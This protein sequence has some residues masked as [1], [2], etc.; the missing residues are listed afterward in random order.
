MDNY[1]TVHEASIKW[2]V[3]E[4][5]VQHL[6]SSGRIVGVLR[7]GRNWIIPKDSSKPSDGRLTTG[8]YVNW[9]KK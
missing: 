6:C 9:R 2:G 7:I 3:S 1:M 5:Q 4:R 8:A